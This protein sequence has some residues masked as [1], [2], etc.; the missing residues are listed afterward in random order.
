[1]DAPRR[2]HEGQV[3]APRTA[4]ALRARHPPR[5]PAAAAR[6][7]NRLPYAHRPQAAH[8]YMARLLH[9]LGIDAV[10]HGFRFSFWDWAAERT[11]VPR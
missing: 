1:M 3:R 10:P 6:R 4:V 7:Q 9:E 5:G 8:P 2:A 11:D